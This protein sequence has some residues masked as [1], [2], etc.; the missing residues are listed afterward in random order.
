MQ[1][2]KSRRDK[3]QD[4][5][6]DNTRFIQYQHQQAYYYK[7]IEPYDIQIPSHLL[8]IGEEIKEDHKD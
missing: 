6:P 8:M 2:E 7:W 5:E 3:K 4:P 1:N